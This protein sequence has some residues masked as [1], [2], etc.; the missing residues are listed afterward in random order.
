M[1]EGYITPS[2]DTPSRSGLYVNQL[3]GV[4]LNLL[5]DL[6][7]DEQEDFMECYNDLYARAV[8]N[9]VSKV[10]S[11]L[12]DKFHFDLKLVSRETSQFSDD[13]NLNGTISG[14]SIEYKL[15]RYGRTHIISVEVYSDSDQPAFEV[16][17][18]DKDQNGRILKTVTVDLVEGLNTINID[19]FFYSDKIF[20][21]YDSSIFV[22]R[23]TTN[24]YFDHGYLFFSDVS[25]LFPCYGQSTGQ[26]TQINGGGFNVI[27]NAVCSIEKV[28]E[29]N[30]NIFKDSFFYM[31][32]LEL[33]FE[34]I[35]SDKFNRWTTLSQERAKELI[36]N[37][38][39]WVEEKTTN[40]VKCLRMR[41]D[42][43][44]FSCKSI[45]TSTYQLP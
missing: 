24:K 32:G 35:H 11:L 14:V 34:R 44:C 37:Y 45:V 15:P 10:Q 7:K 25:C 17:I 27:F 9:F 20:I 31:I 33:M 8:I 41:E 38:V 3:P 13:S 30:I 26:V 19:D 16:F 21:G 2:K 1:L 36:N 12:T 5:D 42:P 40:A 43:I 39:A 22:I 23:Q 18:F 29:Q 4:T 6:T 28:V